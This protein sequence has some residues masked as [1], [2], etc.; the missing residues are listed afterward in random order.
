MHTTTSARRRRERGFTL[1]ELLTAL[2]IIG[3]VASIT[4][5]MM[6]AALIQTEATAAVANVDVIKSVI[7]Q[8]RTEHGTAPPRTLSNTYGETPAALKGITSGNPFAGRGFVVL[9]DIG[10]LYVRPSSPEHKAIVPA[11]MTLLKGR[12]MTNGRTVFIV[13]Q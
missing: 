12:A 7:E 13:A 2:A 3:I 9:Y 5:P 6:R 4:I 1:V 10:T 8:Y 11:I